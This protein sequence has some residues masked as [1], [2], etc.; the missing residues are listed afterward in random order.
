MFTVLVHRSSAPQ[1]NLSATSPSIPRVLSVGAAS[2]V[3]PRASADA[4][5][6]HRLR[7]LES[8]YTRAD[9]KLRA[10][11]EIQ[12]LDPLAFDPED[13]DDDDDEEGRFERSQAGEAA[14][15]I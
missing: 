9:V 12:K 3:A 5:P 2:A 14:A 11:E 4:A 13:D 1:W 6:P 10:Q 8:A 7:E 15:A